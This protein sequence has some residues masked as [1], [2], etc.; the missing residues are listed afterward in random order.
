MEDNPNNQLLDQLPT[1]DEIIQIN[2]NNDQTPSNYIP[3]PIYENAIFNEI[4]LETKLKKSKKSIGC[5]FYFIIIIKN[6]KII[7]VKI[8]ANVIIVVIAK[9]NVALNS[10]NVWKQLGLV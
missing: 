1:Q 9:V 2:N 4:R 6:I 8:V 3:P 5:S 10:I 7:V